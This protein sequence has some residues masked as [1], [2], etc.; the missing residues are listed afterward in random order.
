MFI[1]YFIFLPHG[2]SAEHAALQ[3]NII[4]LHKINLVASSNAPLRCFLEILVLATDFHEGTG[5]AC[6]AHWHNKSNLFHTQ[7]YYKH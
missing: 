4:Q 2:V 5:N 3:Y 6:K 7:V 1:N